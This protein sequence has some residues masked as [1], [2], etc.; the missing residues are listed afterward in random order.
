MT[1]PTL[2]DVTAKFEEI[3]QG[4][5]TTP[6][7]CET[8]TLIPTI[9][10]LKSLASLA[11][12]AIVTGRPVS[13]CQKFMTQHSLTSALSHPPCVCMEHGPAKPDPFPVSRACELLKVEACAS[14]IMIGDTPD[15]IRAAVSAGCTGVG[16][17][18][19]D[20]YRRAAGE[21]K[22][23]AETR[24]GKVRREVRDCV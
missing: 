20:E 24:L 6:G 3:Y 4:T 14:V 11:P 5:A 16:V 22:G 13:D 19:P 15:D 8:E 2:E 23:P 21:G 9:A 17:A 1:P 18:T 10:T 7:L 12:I